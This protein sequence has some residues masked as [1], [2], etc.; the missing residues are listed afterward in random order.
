MSLIRTLLLEGPEELSLPAGSPAPDSLM[1]SP[2]SQADFVPPIPSPMGLGAPMGSAPVMPS[3]G[4]VSNTLT[5]E[6]MNKELVL[7]ITGELKSV[8]NAFEKKFESEDMTVDVGAVYLQSFLE[9][10]AYNA[11]KIE[12]LMGAEA[13][14]EEAQVEPPV[15]AAPPVEAPPQVEPPPATE[16]SPYT[17]PTEAPEA[18]PLTNPD[19]AFGGF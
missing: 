1:G 2:M 11:K 9:Q 8:L 19:E 12:A 3:G 5:K 4:G 16:G 10:L 17:N 18:S 13:Q 6:V 14:A 7:A 15:E